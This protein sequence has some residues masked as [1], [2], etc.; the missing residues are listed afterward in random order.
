MSYFMGELVKNSSI[1]M[2]GSRRLVSKDAS[3]GL[4]LNLA[5]GV[6]GSVLLVKSPEAQLMY[7]VPWLWIVLLPAG[8]NGDGTEPSAKARNLVCASIAELRRRSSAY[9]LPIGYH[10]D[11][12]EGLLA[13]ERAHPSL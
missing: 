3:W 4:L 2:I 1:S 11:E 8:S 12:L 6:V 5:Y 7:L 10:I 13:Q 9:H